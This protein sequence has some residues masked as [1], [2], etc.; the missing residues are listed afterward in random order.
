MIS[1]VEI[2][3]YNDICNRQQSHDISRL[4]FLLKYVFFFVFF[5]FFFFV[6]VFF[7]FFVF[8]LRMLSAVAVTGSYMVNY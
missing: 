8:F 7:F 4:I 5:F 3:I 6:I 1:E 2:T